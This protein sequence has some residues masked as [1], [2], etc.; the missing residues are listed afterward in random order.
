MT[1]H[2]NADSAHPHA[3]KTKAKKPLSTNLLFL[4]IAA[5]AVVGFL[6]GTRSDQIVSVVGP[7]FGLKTYAGD[8]DLSSVQATYKALK[9]NYDGTLDDK[10]LAEGANKGLVAAAGDAYTLFMNSKEV[11]SFDNDLSGTIGGGI[12]AEVGVRQ[13]KITILRTLKS[14]PAEAAGLNAGDVVLSINDQSTAGKTVEQAVTQ[15]RGEAGTTVKL[16]ILRGTEVKEFTITRAIIS[17][18]SVSSSVKDGVGT[19]TITR[20]DGETSTLA[21]AAA[22]DFKNQGVKAIILDLRGNGGGYLT[23]AQD[24]A[25]L[26]L[27]KG[28]VI[29]AEKTNGAVVDTLTSQQDPILAGIP[30]AVLVNA[31]SASASEIVAGALQ[32]HGAAKLVGEKTFGKGSVQKLVTLP[33]GAQ[34]KVT[35]ARWYTPKGKNITKEGVTPDINVTLDQ[36][37]VEAGVDP[38]LDAAKKALGL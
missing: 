24:V 31:G 3:V 4:I 7:A 20:F 18:P 9:A 6:A 8:I 30:T 26:W 22:R 29:V 19:L 15:I 12:G 16:S 37:D 33:E 27:K 11:N 5:T 2:Q 17:N 34:L 38:Q 14:N 13:D 35:I 36:K 10:A 28:Q 32:D 1:T 25:G 21:R 23:A